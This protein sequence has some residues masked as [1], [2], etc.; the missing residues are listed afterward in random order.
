MCFAKS[1]PVVPVVKPQDPVIRHEA[2]AS[3]TKNSQ[4]NELAS[5]FK[6]NIKTSA[7]GLED[8][9]NTAKK[10]LLGE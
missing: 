5:G 3:L 7:L 9:A 2:D 4:N 10:T 8:E 6:Q 1:A